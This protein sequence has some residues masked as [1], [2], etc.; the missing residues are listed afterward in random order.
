MMRRGLDGLYH[1]ALI[2]ASLSMFALVVMV[3]LGV[4]GR[5]LNF[6]V[7]G[8]DA[9]AGYLMAGAGFLAMAPAF[10]RA[11]HIRVSVIMERLSVKNQR[12]FHYFSFIVG[13]II[14]IFI[15]LYALEQVYKSWQ[16]HDLSTGSDATPIFIPQLSMAIGFIL[17]VVAMID[18]FIL[19]YNGK[20][21]LGGDLMNHE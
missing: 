15:A 7:P 1:A 10:K 16:Y 9:Y 4:L 3:L 6:Y 19:F 18:E 20:N 8:T 12:Y 17:L 2:A 13:L 11:D 14:S 21:P 5:Q